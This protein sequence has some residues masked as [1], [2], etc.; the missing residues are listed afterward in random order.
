MSILL[1]GTLIAIL[2]FFTA[3]GS[4]DAG[5]AVWTIDARGSYRVDGEPFF[6]I[7]LTMPPPLGSRT[8]WGRDAL[9]ELVRSGV[10]VYR[11]GPLGVRWTDR[12]VTDAL[13]WADAAAS[14]GVY[15]WLQLR[16]LAAVNPTSPG[17][18]RLRELVD[19]LKDHPGMALWKGFDEPYPRFEPR[20]L[21]FAYH[22]VTNNDPNHPFVIIFAPRSRDRLM[23]AH[24]PDP[25]SLRRYRSVADAFG[26]DVYPVYHRGYGFR[27]PKLHMVGMW[28]RAMRRAIGSPAI[29]TSLQICFAGSDDRFGSGRFVLPTRRQERYMIYDAIVNGAR[30]LTFF[31][32][33][34][35]HCHTRSDAARGW[36]WSFWRRVLR[37]LVREI[38][39]GSPLHAALLRPGTTRPL[40]TGSA[41]TQAISRRVGRTLWVIATR[42]GPSGAT[43]TIRGLPTW[44]R[45]GRRHPSGRAVT[46]HGGQI[47][48]HLDG[49]GVV[50]LR[51]TQP[52]S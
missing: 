8:P 2:A 41:A 44:A 43:V 30:G 35:S 16:E 3:A 28:T 39:I 52:A 45:I 48:T 17:V 50:V 11:T 31:G 38:G 37:P 7:S 33:Q 12:A 36:N 4:P 9:E 32:G 15:T 42:R 13:A 10:T 29:M 14:K 24:P 1:K 49:W 20:D 27:E 5:A 51:F 22:L 18:P 47:R 40:G 23:L 25:P 6:P 21:A 26:V 19:A 46:A 34:L